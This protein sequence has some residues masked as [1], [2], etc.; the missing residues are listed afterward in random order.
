MTCPC[1]NCEFRHL[2]CHA[3]CEVYK[4]FR[5]QFEEMRKDK[6]RQRKIDEFIQ[7]KG[8]NAKYKKK[9]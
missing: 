1:R 7:T 6:A 5:K 9:K 2:G 8:R 4:D 3:E